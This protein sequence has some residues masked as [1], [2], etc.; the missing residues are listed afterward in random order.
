MQH[1]GV[2]LRKMCELDGGRL[3][4]FAVVARIDNIVEVIFESFLVLR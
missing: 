4:Y 2:D 1:L 3:P